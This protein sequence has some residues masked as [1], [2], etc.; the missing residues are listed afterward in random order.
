VCGWG[1]DLCKTIV[2][3]YNFIMGMRTSILGVSKVS[4]FSYD[5]SKRFIAIRNFEI[6]RHGN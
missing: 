5:E 6:A 1:G 3:F 4:K 2:V